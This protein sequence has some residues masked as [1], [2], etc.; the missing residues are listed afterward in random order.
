VASLPGESKD[1]SCGAAVIYE[2][3]IIIIIIIAIT[4]C[5][6]FRKPSVYQTV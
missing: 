5:P 2:V 3:I 6:V 1:P 4:K